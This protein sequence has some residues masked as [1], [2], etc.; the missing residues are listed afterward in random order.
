MFPQVAPKFFKTRV[1]GP[2]NLGKD[3][4]STVA[5]PA[6]TPKDDVKPAAAGNGADHKAPVTYVVSLHGR[7]HKVTVAREP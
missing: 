3:P 5:Q 1:Q 4:I 7:E 2:M 6:A